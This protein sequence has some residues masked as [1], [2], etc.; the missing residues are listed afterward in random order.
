MVIIDCLE[1]TDDKVYGEFI[2]GQLIFQAYN[3]TI[4]CEIVEERY[5]EDKPYFVAT[6]NLVRTIE[7]Y[8]DPELKFTFVRVFT[9]IFT[10]TITILLLLEWCGTPN[11]SSKM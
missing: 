3:K 6:V 5:S 9:I 8:P 2:N 10:L 11:S 7:V 4:P 1:I